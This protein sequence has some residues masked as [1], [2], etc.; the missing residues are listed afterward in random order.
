VGREGGAGGPALA[1]SGPVGGGVPLIPGWLDE[2]EE[3]VARCLCG[4]RALSA[5]ELAEALG[6]SEASAISY[7]T[8]LA[9]AGRLTIERVGLPGG[10]RRAAS[11]DREPV[12][13]AA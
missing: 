5:R 11:E 10:A 12:L 8:L 3:E 4:G 7:I 2:I 1:G 13:S 9:S 6:V